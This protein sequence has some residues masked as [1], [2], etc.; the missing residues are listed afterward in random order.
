MNETPPD[1]ADERRL[2]E[3]TAALRDA[4]A[5]EP[6]PPEVRRSTLQS[7]WA[8]DAERYE[9]ASA[10]RARL[11]RTLAAVAAAVAIVAC[12]AALVTL[13]VQS[14]SEA[15]RRQAIRNVAPP[16]PPPFA[17]ST[18]PATFPTTQA[19]IDAA[20]GT[21][22][23]IG[24]VTYAGPPP[25]P[26]PVDLSP[27]PEC[28]AMHPDGLFDDS[29]LVGPDGGL[30][31]AVVSLRP[32]GDRSLSGPS[33]GAP[34]VLDQRGCRF[35][36]RVLAVAVGQPIVVKNSDPFLHNVHALAVDNPA[37]NFGQPSVDS[38]RWVGAMKVAERFYVRCDI[39]PWMRTTI[40]VFEHP[41]FAVTGPDGAFAVPGSV[42]DGRYLLVAWHERLGEKVAP[43]G[44]IKGRVVLHEFEFDPA[45]E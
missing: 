6:L 13:F 2:D 44:V 42:P 27:V 11:V 31:N 22:V 35:V 36:P 3:L 5:S 38:G 30:A 19:M 18:M 24:R 28:R 40:N 15:L 26:Q 7:L 10:R 33:R 20:G 45:T 4:G 43:I 8:T 37:F 16:A 23:A 41:Y 17:P 14:R 39:H 9:A 12:G 29:L 32:A 34:A 25:A 21:V 1:P